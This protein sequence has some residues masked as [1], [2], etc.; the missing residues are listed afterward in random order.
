MSEDS[1]LKK[2]VKNSP[3]APPLTLARMV[4]AGYCGYKENWSEEDEKTQT[5]LNTI[6]DQ[7]F[8][9]LEG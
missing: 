8:Y 6:K 1:N 7:G 9:V 2:W 5:I 4:M 3:L